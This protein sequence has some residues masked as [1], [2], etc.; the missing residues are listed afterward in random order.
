MAP[1]S[2]RTRRPAGEAVDEREA[3]AKRQPGTDEDAPKPRPPL[4]PYAEMS[5]GMRPGFEVLAAAAVVG[6]AG[7]IVHQNHTAMAA[8]MAVPIFGAAAWW[9]GAKPVKAVM[10]KVGGERAVEAFDAGEPEIVGRLARARRSVAAAS[11]AATGWV[12]AAGAT[13]LDPTTLGGKATI[14]A[15]GLLAVLTGIP[16]LR[17]HRWRPSAK[18]TP[19]RRPEPEPE[20]APAPFGWAMEAAKKVAIWAAAVALAGVGALPATHLDQSTIQQVPG[21]WRAVV[22]SDQPG[23]VKPS[24]FLQAAEQVA[25]A[26]EVDIPDVSI[27]LMP[28]NASQA[29]VTV[30]RE[31]PL[32]SIQHWQGPES[33]LDVEAGVAYI[34]VHADGELVRYRFW[35]TGGA[36]HDLISGA[37]GSGKS[38]L[39]NLLLALERHAY[40]LVP[41]E[42]DGETKM[43][44]KGLIVSRVIDPQFG[45]SFGDWQDYVDW[46]AHHLDEARIL[47]QKTEREMF[48]RNRSFGRQ[49]WYDEERKVWRRG[50]KN[51][52][53]TPE[54]PMIVITIDEAHMILKDPE[55]KRI[56][57]MLG[58]MGRKVGIKLRLI[59]Q[60]PLLTELGG[61][62]AIRDAVAGGNVIVFR[63]ANA[64]SGQVA[65][66]GTLPAAP[67]Q[68]PREW[69]KGK[70]KPGEETTAGLGYVLGAASR[71][72]IMRAFYP[73]ESID[74]IYRD[75][76]LYG[77]PG[78]LDAL[79]RR[80]GTGY[81]DRLDRLEA[82][83][84]GNIDDIAIPDLTSDQGN[85]TCRLLVLKHLMKA[86]GHGLGRS[87]L[88]EEIKKT[89]STRQLS[90]VLRALKQEGWT[91]PNEKDGMHRLTEK[92]I[93][94][95]QEELD[96][97]AEQQMAE[98]AE[99]ENLVQV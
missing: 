66:N 87:A 1:T 38:E 89:H 8:A 78:I 64:L 7:Q 31:N 60:V 81:E 96:Q 69:P 41:E 43:V 4:L 13:G 71:S 40:V 85:A 90:N 22:A 45:Q 44:K 58:K 5:K 84:G 95:G 12:A 25:A 2:T 20:A 6:S 46:F 99:T 52:K 98:Q 80:S 72:S 67:H 16:Y 73:G 18:P 42:V 55:C 77:T 3:P 63:T 97:A 51:W 59:T 19:V 57:A 61:D 92:G 15:G 79:T 68:L 86:P 27:E 32:A 62:M 39:V 94:G 56:V 74:W 29:V 48:A 28:G 36:W 30:Q 11:T 14:T 54:L 37:T 21:G 91:D 50:Q 82:M 76:K 53:P 23:T 75:G 9:L 88:L 24:R 17:F 49:K 65:F 47:L 10:A 26:F 34:G 93:K 35:S 33:T 70:C 83:D